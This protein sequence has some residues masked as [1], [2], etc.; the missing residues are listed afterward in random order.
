MIGTFGLQKITL[1]FNKNRHLY[2]KPIRPLLLWR[3]RRRGEERG[4]NKTIIITWCAGSIVN[5]EYLRE[6]HDYPPLLTLQP[7][8]L[9]PALQVVKTES[10][11]IKSHSHITSSV[12]RI[13]KDTKL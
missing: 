7:S 12:L 5:R 2:M 3:R 9:A 4:L 1:V 11:R 10:R 8:L 13:A 6:F